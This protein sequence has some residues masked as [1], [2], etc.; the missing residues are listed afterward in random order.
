MLCYVGALGSMV[1]LPDTDDEVT[2]ALHTTGGLKRALR[3]GVTNDVFSRKRSWTFAYSK[4]IDEQI[5]YLDALAYGS[6]PGPLRLVDTRRPNR[7]PEDFAA[8]GSVSASNAMIATDASSAAY[9]HPMTDTGTG[10]ATLPPSPMLRGY[11]E[12]Q[13]LTTN[14]GAFLRPYD[15]RY[16]DARWRVPVLPGEDVE[17]GVWFTGP[18]ST[19]LHLGVTYV[20]LAGVIGS[21]D[22]PYVTPDPTGWTELTATVTPPVGTVAA[23]PYV[24][25]DS[26]HAPVGTS[27]LLTAWS[28]GPPRS[29]SVPGLQRV[30][31]VPDISAGWRIGGGGPFVVVEPGDSTYADAVFGGQTVTLHET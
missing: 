1:A 29:G 26:V 30:C 10:T 4:L 31:A 12:W 9:Y 15:S 18:A 14:G 7:L 13:I 23:Y 27:F 24:Q 20:G 3:G 28:M 16:L 5:A 8:G 6:L 17:V 19:S 22:L 25:A 2:I 11:T 21:V